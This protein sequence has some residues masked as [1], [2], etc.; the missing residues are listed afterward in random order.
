MITASLVNAEFMRILS[1][2]QSGQV[3]SEIRGSERGLSSSFLNE[4]FSRYR[5]YRALRRTLTLANITALPETPC[6][7]IACRKL[8][9]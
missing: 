7:A 5:L 1:S 3:E 2:G 8:K 9:F 4:S 6:S